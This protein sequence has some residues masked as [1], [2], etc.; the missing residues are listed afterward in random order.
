[1]DIVGLLGGLWATFKSFMAQLGVA[2]IVMYV[3]NLAT[4]IR[5]KDAQRHRIIEVK[6]FLKHIPKIRKKIEAQMT[7]KPSKANEEL[8]AD[9]EKCD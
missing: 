1:M 2:S 4:M 6:Q 7:D 5:R 9:L 8:Q 3:Y